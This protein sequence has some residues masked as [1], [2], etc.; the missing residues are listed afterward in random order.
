MEETRFDVVVVGAGTAGA[1]AAW[2]FAGR[3]RR[4]ALV[5]NRRFAASG[6]RW[7]NAVAPW[8][9]D[10]AG[11]PRPQ[12][13][14]LRCA[15]GRA[16]MYDRRWRRVQTVAPSP[17]WSCDMRRLVARLQ[18]MALAAGVVAFE[19]ACVEDVACVAGRP[20]TATLRRADGAAE[21]LHAALFVDA[22]GVGGALKR[23][24]PRLA[25]AC[26]DVDG[27]DLCIAAQR[28]HRVRDV[29]AARR[30]LAD[31]GADEHDVLTVAGIDGGFSTLVVGFDLAAAEVEVLVGNI[32]DGRRANP[33]QLVTALLGAEPWLGEVLFGGGGRIPLRRPYDCMTAPGIALLGNAACQVFP[34]H[35]SG[36]GAGMIAARQLAETTGA[37]DDIGSAD[38]L[39]DYQARFLRSHG[40]V[41]AAYDVFRRM[42][43][44]LSTE[45]AERLLG[46]GMLVDAGTRAALDHRM[47]SLSL[48]ELA[49][50]AAASLR[51]PDLA[52]RFAPV[53]A[54]LHLVHAH[55]RR[56]PLRRDPR[57]LRRWAAI[58]ARLVGTR[59]DPVGDL[60]VGAELPPDPASV[61]PTLP[62]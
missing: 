41:H 39:W 1:A 12:A 26:P 51:H 17:L 48:R 59:P 53:V 61:R 8:M 11:V 13:P 47:P 57:A 30:F 33:L 36:I 20:V 9:F 45:E 44:S 29:D 5:D 62:R 6:A 46:S 40:A 3:G 2:Q 43:Q 31:R 24:V 21:R 50:I 32:G 14:E 10:A 52:L 15:T 56:Y 27:D 55:Y 25:A 19:D 37:Y 4:V 23:L 7:V 49:Q 58:A 54:R 18:D 35:G 16:A 34:A 60:A 38:A 28:V 22:G 42:T